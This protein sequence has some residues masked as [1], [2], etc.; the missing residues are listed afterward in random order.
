MLIKISFCLFIIL[1]LN[2]TTVSACPSCAATMEKGNKS[3]SHQKN[4]EGYQYSIIGMLS[5]PMI[6]VGGIGFYI[7]RAVKKNRK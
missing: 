7:R 4:V 1:S 3:A 6:L 2:F 5:M